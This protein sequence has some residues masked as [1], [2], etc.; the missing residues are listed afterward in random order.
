[1]DQAWREGKF[2]RFGQ[3][4]YRADE[5]EKIVGICKEKGLVAPGVYQGHHNPI[6]RSVE[7]ELSSVLR[8]HDLA[9][10]S[11][12]PSAVGVFAGNHRVDWAG[13]RFDSSV[14]PHLL[15]S[16]RFFGHTRPNRRHKL[17]LG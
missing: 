12:S 16:G 5:V 11:W 9:L 6:V 8:K 1:M 4:N 15:L 7:K 14:R 2:S 3:S 10:Y 13:G 17:A